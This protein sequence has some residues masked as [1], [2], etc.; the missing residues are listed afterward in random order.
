MDCALCHEPITHPLCPGCLGT[1]VEEWLR[2]KAPARVEDLNTQTHSMKCDH[3]DRCI[4][5]KQP[6]IV[7]TYCYTR[8][9]FNW[10]KDGTLQIEYLRYFDF[11]SQQT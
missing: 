3:G 9:I 8:E 10:L 5:C 1:A 7:C 11:L 4:R 6:F 2:E